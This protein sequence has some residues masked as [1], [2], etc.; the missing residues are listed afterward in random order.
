MLFKLAHSAAQH[1]RT[2][3]GAALLLE[4]AKDTKFQD[5]QILTQVAA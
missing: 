2:F 4:V 1:G 5:G 3:N